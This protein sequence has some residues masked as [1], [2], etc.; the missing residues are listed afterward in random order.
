MKKDIPLVAGVILTSVAIALWAYK[1][2]D[3]DDYIWSVPCMAGCIAAAAAC[4]IYYL[5]S[6]TK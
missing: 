5:K 3:N 1:R 4:F 6:G 2:Y